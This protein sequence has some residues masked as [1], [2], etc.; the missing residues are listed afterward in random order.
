MSIRTGP[1]LSL[2]PTSCALRGMSVYEGSIRT[3]E[4]DGTCFDVHTW[5]NSHEKQL[6]IN[7]FRA[8]IGIMH[9][10]EM[11]ENQLGVGGEYGNIL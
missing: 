4:Y 11:Y 5:L 2:G 1:R 7:C 9:L 6:I 10:L 8:L 3:G